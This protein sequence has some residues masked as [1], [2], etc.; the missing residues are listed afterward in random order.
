MSTQTPTLCLTIRHHQVMNTHLLIS[1]FNLPRC[2][3]LCVIILEFYLVVS[4][5][6]P[7]LCLII[8]HHPVMNNTSR[9]PY[10]NIQTP[11]LR[12]I[13]SQNLGILSC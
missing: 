3:E 7:R 4:I 1:V 6:T 5:Q 13:I 10:S 2:V 11:M 12:P 9:N 8:R